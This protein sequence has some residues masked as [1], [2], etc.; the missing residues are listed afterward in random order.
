VWLFVCTFY[1]RTRNVECCRM[2]YAQAFCD[3]QGT[4]AINYVHWEFWTDTLPA[5]CFLNTAFGI[6]LLTDNVVNASTTDRHK[7]SVLM[8][9]SITILND[10]YFARRSC[11]ISAD[12]ERDSGNVFEFNCPITPALCNEVFG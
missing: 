1:C 6:V 8:L 4:P 2:M 3:M 12:L 5:L 10:L 9:T 11:R 7:T